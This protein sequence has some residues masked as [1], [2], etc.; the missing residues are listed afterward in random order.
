MK[1]SPGSPIKERRRLYAAY[2]PASALHGEIVSSVA[3]NLLDA[4]RQWFELVPATSAELTREA[5]RIRH[6]VYCQDLGFEPIREDG[7]EMDQYDANAM[8]LLL[9]HVPTD[10]Y[11]GCVRL[12]RVPLD[13]PEEPLPFERVCSSLTKGVMPTEPAQRLHIAEVSRLAVVRQFRRRKGEAAQEVPGSEADL[14][15]RPRERFPHILVALYLGVVSMATLTE[16]TRLYILTEPRLS[17]HLRNLG[18]PMSQI[19]PPIEH[20]GARVPS[21]I[22]VP[23]IAQAM[24]PG[25]LPFYD[26]ILRSIEAAMARGQHAPGAVVRSPG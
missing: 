18:L 11:I 22:H 6:S 17:T 10:A 5:Y 23:S 13:K 14:S 19:G 1:I 3:S 26:H 2:L 9:R 20:R 15:G 24:R 7:M 4:F 25:I 12:V 21:M 8:H 16:V